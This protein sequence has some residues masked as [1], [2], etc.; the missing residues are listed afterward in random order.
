MAEEVVLDAEAPLHAL[1]LR[2]FDPQG[3]FAAAA[4]GAAAP[5]LTLA[6]LRPTETLA[7]SESRAH[8]TDLAQRLAGIAGGQ[9]IDLGGA[10]AAL[11]LRGTRVAEV[12][13]RLGGHGTLP[14]S[15]EARRGRLADVSVLA[16]GVGSAEVLLVVDRA[17]APHLRGWVDATLRDL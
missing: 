1:C 5:G 12:M 7:L 13:A 2:Y 6:R 8:L 4:A 17:Y 3:P 10:L 11:R 15:G 9:V 16:L 14:A